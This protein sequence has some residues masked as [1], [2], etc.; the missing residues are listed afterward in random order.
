[1][2]IC[3]SQA[4]VAGGIAFSAEVWRDE[5]FVDVVEVY[6]LGGCKGGCGSRDVEA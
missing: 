1:M 2:N 6:R 3:D 5:A 4:R